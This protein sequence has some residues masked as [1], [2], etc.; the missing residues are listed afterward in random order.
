M[1]CTFEVSH[2][3]IQNECCLA[4]EYWCE[5]SSDLLGD[6]VQTYCTYPLPR[7]DLEVA[8]GHW[9]GFEQSIVVLIDHVSELPRETQEAC[10]LRRSDVVF[11]RTG[12]GRVGILIVAKRSFELGWHDCKCAK[13]SSILGVVLG[14]A[15]TETAEERGSCDSR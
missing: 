2:P 14:T 13:A 5:L 12:C 4:V 15:K 6:V 11:A 1:D 9:P 8:S 3:Q 7:E 10:G